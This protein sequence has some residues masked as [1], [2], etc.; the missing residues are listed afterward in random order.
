[1]R[2]LGP[3]ALGAILF[4]GA[5]FAQAPGG[6]LV[7]PGS[8]FAN[9]P[10]NGVG[11]GAIQ[12]PGSGFLPSPAGT[13][14]AGPRITGSVPLNEVAVPGDG[15]ER[16]SVSGLPQRHHGRA[17]GHPRRYTPSY[18]GVPDIIAPED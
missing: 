13:L 15:I 1:M 6:G 17:K 18:P 10:S 3:G 14:G 9:G 11:V 12:A 7:A 16:R 8:G 4:A 2:G 5:A